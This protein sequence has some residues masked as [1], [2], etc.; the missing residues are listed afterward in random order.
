MV[1]EIRLRISLAVLLASGAGP[2]AGA[3]ADATWSQGP[4]ACY[5]VPALSSRARL[6][7]TAPSDG[8]LTSQ[9]RLVA[10]KGEFEPVSFVITPRRD[11][12]RLAIR[13]AALSGAGGEIP[14]GNVDI[15]V[16]KCWYQA[17]TAWYSYFGDS[18]RRELVPELLLN[19]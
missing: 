16:V 10:A 17:G 7:D 8:Q 5:A 12:A 11:V 3:A 19:D 9:L 2:V 14:A 18:N 13:A 15:R 1:T 6:P 4:L